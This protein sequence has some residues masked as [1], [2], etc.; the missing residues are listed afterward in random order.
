MPFNRLSTSSRVQLKRMEF[1]HISRPDVATADSIGNTVT[2]VMSPDG[3][4][5]ELTREA[6]H[7]VDLFQPNY[8]VLKTGTMLAKAGDMVTYTYTINNLSSDDS[9]PLGLVSMVDTKT[10]DLAGAA[11]AA[12]CGSLLSGIVRGGESD[13]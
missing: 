1:W 6:S 13:F 11:T 4:P 3:F 8:E 7:E 9:P 10:G 2:V 12:G 5:N